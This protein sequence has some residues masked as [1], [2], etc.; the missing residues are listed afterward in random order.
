[1]YGRRP[2]WSSRECASTIAEREADRRAEQEADRRLLRGEERR[3]PEHLDQQR[4]VPARRLEELADDVVDVRQ[5][6]VVHL[7]GAEPEAR[8]P[9]RT[10]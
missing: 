8:S 1:M 6:P 10:T 2:R 9:R 5:R 4:P 3:V 7:E